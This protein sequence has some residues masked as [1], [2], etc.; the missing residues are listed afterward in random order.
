MTTDATRADAVVV[1]SG[2]NGLAAAITLARAGRDVTVYEAADRPGGGC[3]TSELTLPGVLHD[4][5]SAVHPMALASPFFRSIDLAARG[6][7]WIQPSAPLA[8]PLDGRPAVILEQNVEATAERLGQDG[9]AW[10][11]VFGPLVRDLEKLMPSLLAPVFRVPRHPIALAR[12]GLPALLPATT[13]ARAAFRT[14]EA[15]ALF[16]GLAAHAIYRL[17]R[18]PTA[19]FGLVFGLVGQSL[20]WPIVEGGSNRLVDALVAELQ[21]LGGRVVTG[22]RIGSLRD[23]PARTTV[24]DLAPRGVADVAAGQLPAAAINRLRRFRYGPG[25]CKVD[26]ALS[27]PVP[28]SDPDV[29]RAATVHLGGSL[30]ELARSEAEVGGGRHAERPFVLFVQPS[31]FDR[32][33]APAGTEVGWAYCHV[34]HGSTVDA[35]AAIEAQVE[36]FAPGFRDLIVARH[37]RTAADIER[38]DENYVGGD[39]GVGLTDLRGVFFRPRAALD[40]YRLP[41][42]G[43][44]VCSSATPPGG[45]VHGMCGWHAAQSALRS[46]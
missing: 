24:L 44:F 11:R 29:A 2:P 16:G 46:A 7:R 14:G 30:D 5:C 9:K 42:E 41:G 17:D 36:R 35:S 1:G 8:H 32:T 39:I 25:V 40:P 23:V 20:G 13:F 37:V 26:W 15:R 3:R 45:G 38:Y 18:P 19:A 34:P 22:Q 10:R 28:W 12:F 6:V 43:L 21:A 4:D 31:R 33:R 27:G